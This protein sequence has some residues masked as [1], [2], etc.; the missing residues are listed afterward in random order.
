V[1][2][3]GD[4]GPDSLMVVDGVDIGWTAVCCDRRKVQLEIDDV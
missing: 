2:D 4:D 1:N 3:G